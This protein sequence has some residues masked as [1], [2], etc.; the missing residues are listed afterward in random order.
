MRV[1]A[2]V[3][4]GRRAVAYTCPDMP[5]GVD[6]ARLDYEFA[7]GSAYELVC[8]PGQSAAIRLVDDC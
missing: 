3:L 6:G 5:L 1:A 7:A 4:A 2:E 8:R